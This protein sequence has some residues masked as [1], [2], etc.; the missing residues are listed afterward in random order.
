MILN[1][2]CDNVINELWVDGV[3][4]SGALQP[5]G[6]LSIWSKMKS[7]EISADVSVIA[8]KCSDD[9]GVLVI[10]FIAE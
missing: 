9:S 6:Q 3:P 4:S 2:T 8:I 10:L 1:V 7:M 5:S